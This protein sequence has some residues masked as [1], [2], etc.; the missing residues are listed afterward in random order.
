[1]TTLQLTIA[2]KNSK[3][4]MTPTHT[5]THSKLHRQPFAFPRPF[6][7]LRANNPS[8][9]FELATLRLPGNRSPSFES[10]TVR[11]PLNR[12]PF[13]FPAIVRIPSDRSPS[14]ES[15][16][17]CLPYDHLPSFELA[18][19]CLH[20]TLSLHQVQRFQAPMFNLSFFFCCCFFFF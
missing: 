10:T 20:G 17:L 5:D 4:P 3:S 13:A 16:T 8:P 14:F 7:F 1:M 6:S 9:S 18:T 12:R 11:L 19:L 15:A 2:I